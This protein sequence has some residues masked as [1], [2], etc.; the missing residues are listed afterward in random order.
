MSNTNLYLELKNRRLSRLNALPIKF[1]FNARQFREMMQSWGL[2]EDDTDQ[3][4][5]LPSTGGYYLR[6]DAETIRNTF[7]EVD[8]ELES[9]IRADKDGTGFIKD[10][11]EYELGNHEYCITYDLSPT[12]CALGLTVEEVNAS[13][14]LLNGLRI[15]EKSYMDFCR[16]HNLA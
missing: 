3:I 4:Y 14:A 16:E 13:P 8:T 12:L 7:A 1:A 5:S 2:T 9:A 10:M 6:K 11:F 15:A